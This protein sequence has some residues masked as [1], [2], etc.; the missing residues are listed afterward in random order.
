MTPLDAD[1]GYNSIST[2][3]REHISSIG[4][5][6]RFVAIVYIIFIA[7]GILFSL[8]FLFGA[9]A[10][11]DELGSMIPTGAITA[12]GIFMLIMMAFALYT[13]ILMLKAS[14][15][16]KSYAVTGNPTALE[17]G[18]VNNRTYWLIM[19]ILAII[20][21]VFLVFGGIA[22]ARFLPLIMS[23]ALG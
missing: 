17:K 9:G 15:G 3:A 20:G 23:G 19:G 13:A 7:L 12:G 10:M 8:T 22:M 11:A 1:S 18:F 6:M 14:D 21:L 2:I 4:G 5:W 16:F